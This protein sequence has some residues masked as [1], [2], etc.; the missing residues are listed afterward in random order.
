MGVLVYPKKALLAR[1]RV[2]LRGGKGYVPE[3]LLNREKVRTSLH[4][5]GRKAVPQ[6]MRGE[7]SRARRLL[8]AAADRGLNGPARQ[9]P[10]LRI[11]EQRRLIGSNDLSAAILVPVQCSKRRTR[12]GDDSLLRPLPHDTYLPR[13]SIDRALVDVVDL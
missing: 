3:K 11:H 12:H 1:V 13:L 6:R 7:A 8:E 9:S 5:M 4:E 2:N 10:P